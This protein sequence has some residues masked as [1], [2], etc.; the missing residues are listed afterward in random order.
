M[1]RRKR[2]GHLRHIARKGGLMRCILHGNPGT[3]AGRRLGGLASLRRH[4]ASKSGFRVLKSV[5]EPR[6]SSSLAEALGILFGDGHLSEYQVSVATSRKTDMPHAHFTKALL[7]RLFGVRGTLIERP[8]HGVV[9]L[10]FSSKNMVKYIAG[11]GMPVGNKLHSGLSVPAWVRRKSSWQRALLRGLFDTDGCVFV[12]RHRHKDRIYQYISLS[13]TSY[14]PVLLLGIAE[15]L[16]NCGLAPTHAPGNHAVFLRRREDVARYFQVIGTSNPKHR[17][18]Y[19]RFIGRVP[20][21]S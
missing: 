5:L 21:W 4:M 7:E 15:L 19:A 16:K 3:P 11:L 10:V 1:N 14:S 8:D 9:V 2:L 20:K 6:R 17:E 12:D 18:R 13:F